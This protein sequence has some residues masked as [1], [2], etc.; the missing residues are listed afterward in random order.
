MKPY[1]RADRVGVQI[2]SSLT[3]LMTKKIQD[4]RIEM[5]TISGVKLT[6]DLRIAY[7]YFSV[8]GDEKRVQEA[9]EGFKS[10]CGFIKK[11]LAPKL[12]L[13]YMP[14]LKFIHDA[15]F[16]RGSRID[17]LL[18]ESLGDDALKDDH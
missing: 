5:A 1:P 9:L 15:S 7:V 4:P 14:D 18:K 8:F 12:G 11:S 10:S 13:R 16:D 6:P 17:S 3:E 2:Q